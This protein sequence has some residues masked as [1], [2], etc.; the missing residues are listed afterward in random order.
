MKKIISI[1]SLIMLGIFIQ[2][3]EVQ[4][5]GTGPGEEESIYATHETYLSKTLPT[6]SHTY[7]DPMPRESTRR[8]GGEVH[9]YNAP[10]QEKTSYHLSNGSGPV[11]ASERDIEWINQQQPGHYTIQMMTDTKREAVAKTLLKSPKAGGRAAEFEHRDGQQTEYTGVY[12]TFESRQAAEEAMSKLP[13]D[14]KHSAK[15]E[16]WQNVQTKVTKSPRTN[17]VEPP[18]T[19][20]E[21][22]PN[23]GTIQSTE[24]AV[25]KD[26]LMH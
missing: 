1:T 7:Q 25:G 18:A 23:T 6:S 24:P 3:C 14:L 21:M 22:S 26:S 9:Y 17:N 5:S 8:T 10:V 16:Q 12:G 11:P 13:D 20:I 2:G 4:Q 15:V 19:S